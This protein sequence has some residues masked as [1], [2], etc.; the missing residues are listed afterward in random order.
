MNIEML[1]GFLAAAEPGRRLRFRRSHPDG[2]TAE[3]DMLAEEL[4]RRSRS[5]RPQSNRSRLAVV[6]GAP[7]L[8]RWTFEAL[9]HLRIGRLPARTS[10]LSST[11]SGPQIRGRSTAACS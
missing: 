7:P 1:D 9:P 5:S 4:Q 2:A 8:N 11:V 6:C 3:F 10:Y